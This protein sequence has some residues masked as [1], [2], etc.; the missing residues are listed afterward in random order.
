[1]TGNKLINNTIRHTENRPFPKRWASD[2]NTASITADHVLCVG[3][4]Q[5][6]DTVFQS[7]FLDAIND[8]E[9]SVCNLDTALDT[10]RLLGYLHEDVPPIQ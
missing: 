7:S 2:C 10:Y 4:L 3:V 6:T 1:M 9:W 8:I 5:N